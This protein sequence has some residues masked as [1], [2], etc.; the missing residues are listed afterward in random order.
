SRKG[1]AARSAR[2][3]ARSGALYASRRLGAPGD[4]GARAAREVLARAPLGAHGGERRLGELA[5]MT[6][7]L[8]LILFDPTSLPRY[9]LGQSG[10]HLLDPG[11]APHWPASEGLVAGSAEHPERAAS[12]SPRA[13]N[14]ITCLMGQVPPGW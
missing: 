5:P 8:P 6:A 3:Q 1:R 10:L 13:P 11:K 2:R 14:T 7:G 4:R 12:S 9:G